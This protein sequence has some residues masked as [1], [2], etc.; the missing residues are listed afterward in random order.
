MRQEEVVFIHTLIRGAMSGQDAGRQEMTA[1]ANVFGYG[2]TKRK[3]KAHSRIKSHAIKQKDVAHICMAS[4]RHVRVDACAGD[5]IF[6]RIWFQYTDQTKG[7]KST[8]HKKVGEE[9]IVE[10][11]IVSFRPL[12]DDRPAR[13]QVMTVAEICEAAKSWRAWRKW[14]RLNPAAVQKLAGG[15]LTEN[16]LASQRPDYVIT[17]LDHNWGDCETHTSGRYMCSGLTT[18]RQEVHRDC[19]CECNACWDH[20]AYF[21]KT[22]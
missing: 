9:R 20:G 13:Q 6:E 17:S 4:E 15:D 16:F 18:S 14:K 12:Y 3:I 7:K 21:N 11:G 5:P 2:K 8:R 1:L 10:N 22:R 19:D